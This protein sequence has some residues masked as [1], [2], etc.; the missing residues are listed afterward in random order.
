MR[1]ANADQSSL[2]ILIYGNIYRFNRLSRCHICKCAYYSPLCTKTDA[3]RSKT[4]IHTA[5][6]KEYA[7]VYNQINVCCSQ[8]RKCIMYLKIFKSEQINR[9]FRIYKIRIYC[10]NQLHNGNMQYMTIIRI[11][12]SQYGGCCAYIGHLLTSFST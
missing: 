1:F 8:P 3:Q 7:C 6:N 2:S 12:L 5:S 10:H 9:L 11:Y 4:Y